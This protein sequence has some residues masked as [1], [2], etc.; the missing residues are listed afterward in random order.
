MS[1]SDYALIKKSTLTEIGN[2][3]RS[4]KGTDEL[5]DPANFGS[6]ISA[7][8]GGSS[9]EGGFTVNFHD[10]DGVLIESHSAE[11]GRDIYAPASFNEV[12]YWSD[13][14]GVPY[15][16]PLTINEA[17]TVLNLYATEAKTCAQIL[18]DAFGVSNEECPQVALYISTGNVNNLRVY[19]GANICSSMSSKRYSYS[20]SDSF[21]TMDVISLIQFIIENTDSFKSA[22]VYMDKFSDVR[23][24]A[25][26]DLD[27]GI[28]EGRLDQVM[29]DTNDK[30]HPYALQEKTVTSSGDVV[31]DEGY[32][33]LSKVSV[34]VESGASIDGGYTVNF[35]NPDN[36]LIEF[37]GALFGYKINAP[38]DYS[39]EMWVDANGA[40]SIF[41]LTILESDGI[42][43]LDL[44]AVGGE[45]ATYLI[46]STGTQ[47]GD[48]FF[49][50]DGVPQSGDN[51]I[52]DSG[53]SDLMLKSYDTVYSLHTGGRVN[54]SIVFNDLINCSGYKYLAVRYLYEHLDQTY[55]KASIHLV[56]TNTPSGSWGVPSSSLKSLSLVDSSLSTVYY[57]TNYGDDYL[58]NEDAY[59]WATIALDDIDSFYL[60]FHSCS[61][62]LYVA[63]VKL[64]R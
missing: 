34:N 33:G 44:Y 54:H 48:T 37:H 56:D 57:T 50:A 45:S 30:L 47:Y 62:N 12:N 35:Y 26:F 15:T 6:E 4:Q 46:N 60:T 55:N 16:L 42:T 3:I 61:Y 7:I 32:Y 1:Y 9:I 23:Y 40:T 38:I 18:Y 20:G 39:A 11:L 27:F 41:P 59:R 5:I 25:N 24:F 28:F 19:F 17:D 43:S 29:Y 14:N 52:S 58:N 10:S 8:E 36:E 2:A 64:V 51:T 22:N 13:E 49:S 31:P 21:Y 63:D 53:N